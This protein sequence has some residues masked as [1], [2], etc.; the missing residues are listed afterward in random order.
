MPRLRD[1]NTDSRQKMYLETLDPYDFD[2]CFI[3]TKDTNSNF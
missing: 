3:N 2:N 1:M